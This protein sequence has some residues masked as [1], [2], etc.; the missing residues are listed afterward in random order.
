MIE[1]HLGLRGVTVCGFLFAVWAA[2]FWC[3]DLLRIFPAFLFHHDQKKKE[4]EEG[5]GDLF[6]FSFF[7]LFITHRVQ[8][9]VPV[10][11]ILLC[12]AWRWQIWGIR[13]HIPIK[14]PQKVYCPS[15]CKSQDL[16]QRPG[17]EALACRQR[18][19]WGRAY[20]RKNDRDEVLMGRYG[21]AA[22]VSYAD[23]KK[24]SVFAVRL[25]GGIDLLS[26][27]LTFFFPAVQQCIV[28]LPHTFTPKALLPIYLFIYFAVPSFSPTLSQ[29]NLCPA[30]P[31]CGRLKQPPSKHTQL[32]CSSQL[33]SDEIPPPSLLPQN[34]FLPHGNPNRPVHS[35]M[36]I[37]VFTWWEGQ[38]GW[39]LLASN[40]WRIY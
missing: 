29:I 12:M 18:R 6:F 5:G 26:F 39:K 21:A 4:E 33:P 32:Y 3:W 38:T 25:R 40:R 10:S 30:L 31:L 2:M 24:K 36:L 17:N 13:L 9:I 20:E 34:I 7:L 35:L 8:I 27:W 28:S 23:R 19:V 37:F 16:S 11:C 1:G 22:E 15:S 14:Q